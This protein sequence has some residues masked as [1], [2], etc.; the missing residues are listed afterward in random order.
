MG[1]DRLNEALR[2]QAKELDREHDQILARVKSQVG[3]TESFESSL[4]TTLRH[5]SA[6]AASHKTLLTLGLHAAFCSVYVR[7]QTHTCVFVCALVA[8]CLCVPVATSD[9]KHMQ[10][11]HTHTHARA[12][13]H[14]HTH[15]APMPGI[16]AAAKWGH[17]GAGQNART[18]RE[19]PGHISKAADAGTECKEQGRHHDKRCRSH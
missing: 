17:S 13:T 8:A 18:G 2:W 4:A 9:T 3:V 7:A 6:D 5:N 15:R 11:W 14:T 1:I 10:R 16:R 12:R 19:T